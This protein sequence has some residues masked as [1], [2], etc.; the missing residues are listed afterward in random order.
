MMGGLSCAICGL[1]FELDAE[2]RAIAATA[3]RARAHVDLAAARAYDEEQNRLR[4]PHCNGH[5]LEQDTTA[6]AGGIART[7]TP[8]RGTGLRKSTEG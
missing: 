3:E 8:C 7:C 1:D 6:S 4:C 5:G 2:Q